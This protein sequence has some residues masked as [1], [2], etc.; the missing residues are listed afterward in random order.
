[1]PT[2]QSTQGNHQTGDPPIL[3]DQHF[4]QLATIIH[5]AFGIYLPHS[6][7]ELIPRRLSR[8]LTKLG[9]QDYGQYVKYIKSH[10]ES[11]KQILANAISTNLTSFFREPHHFECLERQIL[12]D[13]LQRNRTSKTVRIWS[14]GCSTGE[15]PYSIAM[16]VNR[17]TQLKGWDV[18]ILATDLD[19]DILSRAAAGEY[20]E[21][22]LQRLPSAELRA[23]FTQIQAS[24]ALYAIDDQL[25]HYVHFKR[26]NFFEAWPMTRQFDVIFCRNAIIYFDMAGQKR[27][28]AGF[29]KAQRTGA[30]LVVGH[31]ERLQDITDDYSLVG[32]T[33]YQKTT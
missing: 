20:G 17:I 1:M 31:S 29:A 10:W 21:T 4:A 27:L 2:L 24:P 9:L 6:K 5:D 33:V 25:K 18:K 15:E 16:V 19:T 26:L 11:E 12:P 3:N 28:M 22:E 8:R 23:H 14:A 13:L 30:W 32:R 7:R